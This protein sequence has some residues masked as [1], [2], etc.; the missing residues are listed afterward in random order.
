MGNSLSDQLLKAGLVNDAKVKKVRSDKHKSLKQQRK[1]KI[2]TVNETT[3]QFQ[4]Q[5]QRKV[6]KDRELNRQIKEQ[7]EKNAVSAQI[8]QLIDLNK[9]PQEAE[10]TAFNF[11]DGTKVKTLYL[12]D[13]VR[14]HLVKGRLAIVSSGQSYQVIP[15]GVAEKIRQRDTTLIVKWNEPDLSVNTADDENLYADYKIPDDL[16]W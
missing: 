16:I 14:E 11:S 9:L 15:A 1:H 6:E 10:G 2:E 5:Q 8:K 7:A 12:S 3:Q 4:K 13:S